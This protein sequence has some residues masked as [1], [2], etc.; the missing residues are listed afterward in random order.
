MALEPQ[1]VLLAS[2]LPI[3]AL[4]Y[5]KY[6]NDLRDVLISGTLINEMSVEDEYITAIPIKVT[7]DG[8]VAI[9]NAKDGQCLASKS[10]GTDLLCSLSCKYN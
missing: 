7:A 1:L 3:T 8:S 2:D 10:H 4:E 5:G 6:H 9:W